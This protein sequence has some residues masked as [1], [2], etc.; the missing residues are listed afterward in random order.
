MFIFLVVSGELTVT[1]VGVAGTRVAVERVR[2]AACVVFAD[3]VAFWLAGVR[4]QGGGYGVG[5]PYVHLGA[6]TST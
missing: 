5:F 4:R 2:S 1:P 3:G 6:V